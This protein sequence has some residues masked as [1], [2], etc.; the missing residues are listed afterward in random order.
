MKEFN[1]GQN[2]HSK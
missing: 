2:K 1:V